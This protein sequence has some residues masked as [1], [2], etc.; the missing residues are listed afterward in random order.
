MFE[1][2]H[3]ALSEI[4]DDEVLAALPPPLEV[5]RWH[6]L[7]GVR[8][9]SAARASLHARLGSGCTLDLWPENLPE[10]RMRMTL[11]ADDES[12]PQLV[13]WND[14]VQLQGAYGAVQLS[15][16]VRWLRALT[17]ID[18][19]AGGEWLSSAAL[20]SLY[21]TPLADSAVLQRSSLG[22]LEDECI[23]RWVLHSGRHSLACH[24]RASAATWCAL[25]ARAEWR[26]QAAS[27]SHFPMLPISTSVTLGRHTLPHDVAFALRPGDVI[28]PDTPSF[29]CG[30][31]G[32]LRLGA[33]T[34]SV[35][36]AA[37]NH[38]EILS[39]EPCME[40]QDIDGGAAALP[41]AEISLVD[42]ERTTAS[43]PALL[44]VPVTLD[45][46]LGRVQMPLGKLQ[47]L[48]VGSVLEITHGSPAEV[49]IDCGGR[50]L[51]HAEVLNVDGRLGLRVTRWGGA[52]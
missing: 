2:Q 44:A 35:T 50:L 8:T 12:L 28:I 31:R 4:S 11:Y 46:L 17:G 26:K 45:F 33:H 15:N 48:A 42:G 22:P 38:L 5:S 13:E 9:M 29:T 49:A 19:D 39:L 27:L 43:D 37:P 10:A 18:L 1:L 20:G 21:G 34:L 6:E 14:P 41:L 23:L 32:R 25:L 30:G 52:S 40:P 24:A 7:P 47:Q 16:G 51:G 3:L 36:Y